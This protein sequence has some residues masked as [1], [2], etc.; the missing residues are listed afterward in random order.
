LIFEVELI[1]IPSQAEETAAGE[2]AEEAAGE[3]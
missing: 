3:G 1:S 2:T